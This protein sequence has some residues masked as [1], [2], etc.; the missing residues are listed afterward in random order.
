[1][2]STHL[3]GVEKI[4]DRPSCYLIWPSEL[5]LLFH[6][7]GELFLRNPL[8]RLCNVMQFDKLRCPS[9]QM[10]VTGYQYIRGGGGHL[11]SNAASL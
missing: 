10:T 8:S 4:L 1:M 2:K 5:T 3:L 7:E 11:Q 6:M 9:F